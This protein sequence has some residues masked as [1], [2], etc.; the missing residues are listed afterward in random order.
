MKN[1]KNTFKLYL[2]SLSKSFQRSAS[3]HSYFVTTPTVTLFY[4]SGISKEPLLKFFSQCFKELRKVMQK[5][6]ERTSKTADLLLHRQVPID[7]QVF[8]LL[9]FA[10]MAVETPNGEM[11]GDGGLA[12]GRLQ[13]HEAVIKDVNKHYDR[14][15]TWPQDALHTITAFAIFKLYLD[16]YATENRL[17]RQPT[18]EDKARIWNGGPNGHLK[19]GTEEYGK[20][21]SNM[22][23]EL[24]IEGQRV[25]GPGFDVN[26]VLIDGWPVE[27]FMKKHKECRTKQK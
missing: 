10:V 4:L 26:E 12:A 27:V 20:Q 7:I 18:I 23:N 6:M 24:K 19:P 11:W 16:I 21:V 2:M 5:C 17:G 8:S 25:A 15:Y 9:P 3:S 14:H 22:Y 1:L 13:I